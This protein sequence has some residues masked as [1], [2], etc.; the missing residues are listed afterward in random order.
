[1]REIKSSRAFWSIFI[2]EGLVLYSASSYIYYRHLIYT[3][4]S[5][6][7]FQLFIF[8]ESEHTVFLMPQLIFCSY[9]AM[10]VYVTNKI[11]FLLIICSSIYIWT[12]FFE[13]AFGY[14][15]IST[16]TDSSNI[17]SWIVQMIYLDRLLTTA[18]K[19]M[20]KSL[21]ENI[22]KLSIVVQM[23]WIFGDGQIFSDY[24]PF[25]FMEGYQNWWFPPVWLR[26]IKSLRKIQ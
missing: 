4:S 18:N 12:F 22:Q 13:R 15:L 25:C 16:V 11:Y 9:R 5:E 14:S 20:T 19:T 26:F 6:R 2:G 17:P 21:Q 24:S 3:R 8:S 23:H 10:L 1:M 7:W